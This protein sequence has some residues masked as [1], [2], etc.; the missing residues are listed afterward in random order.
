MPCHDNSY[1]TF[2]IYEPLRRLRLICLV[3]SLK[4]V[5][6][7]NKRIAESAEPSKQACVQ[8]FDNERRSWERG[9]LSPRRHVS[10]SFHVAAY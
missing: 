1:E 8:N 3:V 4:R 6:T 10:H 2:Y 7:I 9:N 5:D